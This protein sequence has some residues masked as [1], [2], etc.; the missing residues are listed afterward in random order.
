[1]NRKKLYSVFPAYLAALFSHLI[2]LPLAGNLLINA[3]FILI[4]TLILNRSFKPAFYFKSLG[5][6]WGVGFWA[7]I[8]AVF[9]NFAFELVPYHTIEPAFLVDVFRR[10]FRY[11]GFALGVILIFLVNFFV[12]F[13]KALNRAR[14]LKMW[15]R[16]VFSIALAALNAPYGIFVTNEWLRMHGY[17]WF[18]DVV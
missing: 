5:I 8:L 6:S 3:V 16:F 4:I 15:Q 10:V 17:L 2:L 18:Y 7:V 14:S 1:M 9:V 11:G 13:G 12:T